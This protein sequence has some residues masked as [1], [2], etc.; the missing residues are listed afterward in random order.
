MRIRVVTPNVIRRTS[1]RARRSVAGGRDVGRAAN[2]RRLYKILGSLQ[3]RTAFA[4][5][6]NN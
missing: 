5:Q 1:K 3:S 4:S 2:A 6:C